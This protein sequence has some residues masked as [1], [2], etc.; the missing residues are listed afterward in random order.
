MGGPCTVSGQEQGLAHS[1]RWESWLCLLE[2]CGL[3]GDRPPLPSLSLLFCKTGEVIEVI[4]LSQI[5]IEHLLCS[6][7]C[8]RLWGYSSE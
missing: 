7:L 4:F 6:R 3:G 5:F 1:P 2:P 8:S